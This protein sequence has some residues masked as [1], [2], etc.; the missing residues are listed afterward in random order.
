MIRVLTLI[1]ALFAS[2]VFADNS[3]FLEYKV[4]FVHAMVHAQEGKIDVEGY[5]LKPDEFSI[6]SV[7]SVHAFH[8]GELVKYVDVVIE[9]E[10]RLV[11]DEHALDVPKIQLV[12]GASCEP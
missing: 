2:S 7:K 8:E 11:S 12:N 6:N 5:T 10:C 1:T 9:P 3:D 4:Y